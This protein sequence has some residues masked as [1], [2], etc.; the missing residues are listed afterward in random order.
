MNFP[1]QTIYTEQVKILLS[2]HIVIGGAAKL[3]G[4]SEYWV[5]KTMLCNWPNSVNERPFFCIEMCSDEK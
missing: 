5:R 2:F 4:Y 3:L 1:R